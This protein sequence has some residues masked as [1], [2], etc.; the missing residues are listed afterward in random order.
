MPVA[1]RAFKAVFDVVVHV[2]GVIDGDA[3][4]HRHHDHRYHVERHARIAHDAA[5]QEDWRY[6][7]NHPDK[8]RLDAPECKNHHDGDNHERTAEGA[9]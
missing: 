5:N 2:D 4:N 6:V 8:A 9:Q 1:A 7:W 3:Q